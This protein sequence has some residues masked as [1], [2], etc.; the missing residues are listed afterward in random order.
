ML[1]IFDK[2][3]RNNNL[4]YW[5]IGGTLIGAI[6]MVGFHD[7]DVDIGMLEEDHKTEKNNKK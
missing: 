2:I 1:K 3:C 6:P 5:C 4:K 7:G